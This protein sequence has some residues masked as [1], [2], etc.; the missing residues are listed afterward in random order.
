MLL[1][2]YMH[3][4][5]FTG[6]KYL[7]AYAHRGGADQKN[8]IA[9]QRLATRSI[10]RRGLCSTQS[11][12]LPQPQGNASC[13]CTVSLF[14]LLCGDG[15]ACAA[16]R[17][18]RAELL[19]INTLDLEHVPLGAY[20]LCMRCG[21]GCAAEPAGF[22]IQHAAPSSPARAAAVPTDTS[23]AIG[24]AAAEAA[25]GDAADAPAAAAAEHSPLEA[26]VSETADAPS[27]AMDE[28]PPADAAAAATTAA[29]AADAASAVEEPSPPAAAAAPAASTDSAAAPLLQA[30]QP[31]AAEA[32]AAVPP[33]AT[34]PAPD[35]MHLSILLRPLPAA[36][37][38]DDS[39][40]PDSR[41]GRGD[42]SR[43]CGSGGAPAT[44]VLAAAWLLRAL[45]LAGSL[46]LA[47]PSVTCA[48]SKVHSNCRG[49]ADS[50]GCSSAEHYHAALDSTIFL[51]P[52]GH[53]T[54]IEELTWR[55]LLNADA[56]RR[57]PAQRQQ[58]HR[59]TPR[60]ARQ[61]PRRAIVG[62]IHALAVGLA[63]PGGADT[64]LDMMIASSPS[65]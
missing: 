21:S 52:H 16:G 64:S 3:R 40:G 41:P 43:T 8:T 45:V 2:T 4:N 10:P 29:D 57:G 13:Q 65:E 62:A 59:L 7:T 6:C 34:S 35:L 30:A 50:K 24:A 47:V 15:G 63:T 58:R 42:G 14:M 9:V 28:Q 54:S 61:R 55:V 23:A 11:D 25:T 48:I 39:S 32:A 53:N 26:T 44:A 5:Q 36:A 17:V 19:P 22:R 51:Q 31:Q 33:A 60:R 20:A 1:I 18:A 46:V 49:H 27:A 38:S 56:H 12:V 37:G